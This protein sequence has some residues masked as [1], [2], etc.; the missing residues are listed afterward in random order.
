MSAI[1]PLHL[2]GTARMTDPVK[3]RP[4]FILPL[5]LGFGPGISFLLGYLAAPAPEE[6]RIYIA[7]A[8]FMIAAVLCQMLTTSLP[9]QRL[10]PF[11]WAISLI[12]AMGGLTLWLHDETFIKMRPT[13]HYAGAAAFLA[14]HLA[15]FR[16]RLEELMRFNALDF[17]R[18]GQTKMT[19]LLIG[20]SGGM[21]LSNELVWRHG[22]DL[23]WIAFQIWGP[24]LGFLIFSLG[25]IPAISRHWSGQCK[26][27]STD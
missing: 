5:A 23:F 24:V 20:F 3:P 9:K 17:D 2:S 8:V 21:A 18:A 10:W 26:V 11:P 6:E 4:G 16:P 12:V 19:L 25:S 1:I 22:S 14:V 7:T 15:A 27:R 13:V